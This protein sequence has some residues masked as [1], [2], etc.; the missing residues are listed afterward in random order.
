[1]FGMTQ[2]LP[3][4][5][6]TSESLDNFQASWVAKWEVESSSVFADEAFENLEFQ[7]TLSSHS[8]GYTFLGGWLLDFG[9]E[10]LAHSNI[11]TNGCKILD[12]LGVR[13]S[14]RDYLE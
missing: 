12:R 6:S 9:K 13:R 1:M 14:L 3:D 2:L 11:L 8:Q 4:A 5:L 10:S 7:M